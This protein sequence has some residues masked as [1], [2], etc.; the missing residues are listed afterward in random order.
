MIVGSGMI[1]NAFSEHADCDEVVIFASGVS[2]SKN[3]SETLFEREILLLEEWIAKSEDKLFVY[4]SS[5]KHT[6]EQLSAS[7]YELHKRKIERMI[8]TKCNSF[9]I[10]RL[11]QVAG[12]TKSPTFVRSI[13][14]LVEQNQHFYLESLSTRNLVL[15]TDVVN[16]VCFLLENKLYRNMITNI[17]AR[18]SYAVIEIVKKI[19]KILG[20]DANYS[21]V[22]SG[23][24]YDIDLSSLNNLNK[25]FR[26]FDDNYLDHVLA[27][28]YSKY[29]TKIKG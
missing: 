16:V 18:H 20:R 10:F 21:L 22:N 2:N 24:T 29:Y 17:A 25:N 6:N 28:Y 15:I 11:P 26:I 4:F 23:K 9:K 1:A 7:L 27:T 5:C 19:E 8:I 3:I 14:D 13:F 12:E